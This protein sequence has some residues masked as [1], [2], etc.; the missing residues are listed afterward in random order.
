M[1]GWPVGWKPGVARLD[2]FQ[3]ISIAGV[4]SLGANASILNASKVSIDSLFSGILNGVRVVTSESFPTIQSAIDDLP[5]SGGVVYVPAGIYDITAGITVGDGTNSAQSTKHNISI[6]GAGSGA[7]HSTIGTG[8]T[9]IRWT[10]ASGGGPMM[11]VDGP[12]FNFTMSGIHFDAN[13]LADDGLRLINVSQHSVEDVIV[14][15]WRDLAYELN[16]VTA[17]S[18]PAG[19]AHG[20]DNGVWRNIYAF[21]PTLTSARGMLLDGDDRLTVDSVKN[22]FIGLILQ[23]GTAASDALE[24]GYA[25]NN[26]FILTTLQGTGGILRFTQQS[27]LTGFPKNN[28]FVSCHPSGGITGTS[29]TA[30]GNVFW[31]FN[32]DSSSSLIPNIAGII[33]FSQ[34]EERFFGFS[35]I[36]DNTK[37]YQGRETGGT[38]RDFARIDGSNQMIF[39][40]SA[41]PTFINS[42]ANGVGFQAREIQSITRIKANS[43]TSLVAG[44]FSLSAGWGS[45]A[46][47]SAVS[48][49]DA[50]FRITV[51][52]AGSGQ[53]ANPTITLTFKDGSWTNA[54]FAAFT[55][56]GGSQLSITQDWTTTATTLVVTWR[57]TPVAAETYTFEAVVMG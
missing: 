39:G 16:T 38:A 37:I 53:G 24:L 1:T 15:K 7:G 50:R 13:D 14:T 5:A 36:I 31:P 9:R 21:N 49:T 57:G 41:L 34:E 54:P 26:T 4:L 12:L 2:H 44:D 51:T 45:T 27:T 56:N 48:G 47:I 19:V 20:M 6:I 55:R 32:S 33:G 8:A 29:G 23:V 52:S 35:P 30:G 22:V 25:D 11:S 28:T 17:A 42:D 43:G 40:D 3:D 18:L 10:G 46:S